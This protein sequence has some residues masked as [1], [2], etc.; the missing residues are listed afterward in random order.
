MIDLKPECIITP[1][2]Y[3]KKMTDKIFCVHSNYLEVAEAVLYCSYEKMFC[4][5]V[6]PE[7]SAG[8]FRVKMRGDFQWSEY[9]RFTPPTRDA[10]QAFFVMK[11]G[12]LGLAL[13]LD[14]PEIIVQLQFSRG[15]GSDKRKYIQCGL[16]EDRKYLLPPVEGV[17]GTT[18]PPEYYVTDQGLKDARKP[19]TITSKLGSLL[20]KRRGVSV[21]PVK[22]LC[23][24]KFRAVG[25]VKANSSG[26]FRYAGIELFC[27]QNPVMT[28][29]Y[30]ERALI[31]FFKGIPETSYF[32][33]YLVDAAYRDRSEEL[34]LTP[35]AVI[36]EAEEGEAVMWCT[37]SN[38]RWGGPPTTIGTI[39]V[40][41]GGSRIRSVFTP[42]TGTH[43][44]SPNHGKMLDVL[45]VGRG[46]I[47]MNY[48]TNIFF[49]FN[50]SE[51]R[52][53]VDAC[54]RCAE[55]PIY[56]FSGP[57]NVSFVRTMWYEDAAKEIPF[58]PN[59]LGWLHLTNTNPTTDH[60]LLGSPTAYFVYDPKTSPMS[61]DD[62]SATR[63]NLANARVI[64]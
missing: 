3:L 61:Q 59:F 49:L 20:K 9:M 26:C 8:W 19:K 45:D 40:S 52:C 5:H 34:F 36:P 46:Q 10:P 50:A 63:H 47:L 32:H 57:G 14:S 29:T 35:N 16:S 51:K 15:S 4:S 24:I 62:I 48:D 37:G 31:P 1:D 64:V 11:N 21:C 18:R 39:K 22:D 30:A 58:S 55:V 44:T 17:F 43:I 25:R 33:T 38:D 2:L 56:E 6:K 27:T 23:V 12:S 7:E 53:A 28:M 41:H 42:S 60:S 13:P 54:V